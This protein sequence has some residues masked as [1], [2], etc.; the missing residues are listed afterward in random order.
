MEVRIFMEA[1]GLAEVVSEECTSVFT[2]NEGAAAGVSAE[3]NALVILY[4]PV[5][6]E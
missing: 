1:E 2:E 3:A 4:R 6:M 5:P